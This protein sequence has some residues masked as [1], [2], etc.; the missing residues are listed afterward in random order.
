MV[1]VNLLMSAAFQTS[2][3]VKKCKVPM[4]ILLETS[5]KLL[6]GR[7]SSSLYREEYILR[8]QLEAQRISEP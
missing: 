8:T 4:M 5:E 3:S 1:I 7:M 6:L 2:S